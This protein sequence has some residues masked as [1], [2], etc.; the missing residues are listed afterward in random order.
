MIK[1]V[2]F[3]KVFRENTEYFV[4]QGNYVFPETKIGIPFSV[5]HLLL[6]LLFVGPKVEDLSKDHQF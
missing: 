4:M 6:H 2:V 3:T 1:V 5:S